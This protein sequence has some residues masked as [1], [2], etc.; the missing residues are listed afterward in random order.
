MLQQLRTIGAGIAVLTICYALSSLKWQFLL[1]G[2]AFAS[3]AWAVR[4][5]SAQL[6]SDSRKPTA[7]PLEFGE[8]QNPAQRR[9]RRTGEVARPNVYSFPNAEWEANAGY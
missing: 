3:I 7:Q 8:R 1:L 4:S 5:W 9:R 6:S 2:F